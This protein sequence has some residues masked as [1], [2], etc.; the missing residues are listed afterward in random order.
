MNVCG[1]ALV[2]SMVV[3][4]AEV[5]IIMFLYG[6][7]MCGDM[8]W[9]KAY[10][11]YYIFTASTLL[12]QV[13]IWIYSMILRKM[14]EYKSGYDVKRKGLQVGLKYVQ[15]TSTVE[16]QLTLTSSKVW[17]FIRVSCCQT[18]W[19]TFLLWLSSFHNSTWMKK[20]P[21]TASYNKIFG[22]GRS[23]AA[24]IGVVVFQGVFWL[25]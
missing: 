22:R 13:V 12:W 18:W 15:K 7:N 5:F 8:M 2:I 25:K 6:G 20:S 1:P 21:N 19:K 11:H 9:T 17:H 4:W 23:S 14:K 24:S 16:T 3:L 10:G